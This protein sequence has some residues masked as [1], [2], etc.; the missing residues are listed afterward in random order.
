MGT[1]SRSTG[2][3]LCAIHLLSMQSGRPAKTGELADRLSV[4][5]ASVTEMLPTLQERGLATYEKYH[6]AQLTPDGER[7]ARELLWKHCVAENFLDSDLEVS[8]AEDARDIGHAM[9]DEVAASL[10]A[11]IDHPCDGQC[12]A[13]DTEYA[14]CRDDVRGES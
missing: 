5:A 1:V 2:R 12:G 4:S 11:Y 9:S 7:T 3:Y 10:R 14:E 13:P 6:G 8:E